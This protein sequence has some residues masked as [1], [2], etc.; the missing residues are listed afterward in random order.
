MVFPTIELI[1]SVET[2]D[3]GRIYLTKEVREKH[4]ER[5]RILDLPNRIVLIPIADNPLEAAREAVGDTFEGKTPEELREKARETAK[6]DI[7]RE[8]QELEER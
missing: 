5:F 6:A 2:D 7:E 3:R 8:I 4:G 1:M